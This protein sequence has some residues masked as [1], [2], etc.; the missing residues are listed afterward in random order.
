MTCVAPPDAGFLDWCL[1]G[2]GSGSVTLLGLE[3]GADPVTS[4]LVHAARQDGE[5]E[6]GGA[7][8]DMERQDNKK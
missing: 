5:E 4:T 2:H 1:V 8:K 6:G 7:K 3:G